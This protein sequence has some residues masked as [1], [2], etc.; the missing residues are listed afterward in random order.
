MVVRLHREE[1]SMAVCKIK[2]V[3]RCDV[4]KV[5]DLV[6]VPEHFA[7]RSELASVESLGG[8]RF[9]EYTKDGYMNTYSIA[10]SDPYERWELNIENSCFSGHWSARFT[11]ME[12]GST[13]LELE[14]EVKPTS[15]LMRIWAKNCLMKKQAKYMVELQ[16][17]LG[18]PYSICGAA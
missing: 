16:S 13:L 2:A 3:F 14:E 15:L 17:A 4:K 10:V 12:D 18:C 8:R 6:T 11:A 9:K 5:W 1:S 7:W